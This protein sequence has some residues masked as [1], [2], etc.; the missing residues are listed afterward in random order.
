MPDVDGLHA[1]AL[2]REVDPKVRVVFMSGNTGAYTA[3]E[4]LTLGAV[5]V[6]QKPFGNLAEI[7]EAL[8]AAARPT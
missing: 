8:R 3:E 6:M 4:L 5:R 7:P 1:F 2:M